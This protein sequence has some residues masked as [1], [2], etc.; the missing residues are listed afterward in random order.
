MA[1][2]MIMTDSPLIS[3][4][5]SRV[6]REIALG[7]QRYGHHIVYLGWFSSPSLDNKM[8]F[9]LYRTNNMYYGQDAFDSVFLQEQPE[10][11]LT[12]GDEWMV[13][14]LNNP[15]YCSSRQ[16]LKWIMYCPVDGASWNG[17]IPS[18]WYDTLRSADYLIAYTEYGRRKILHS[19]PELF[20]QVRVIYHGVD[21]D[22]FRPLD[23]NLI[24]Q[25]RA[26]WGLKDKIVFLM[27]SRNQGRKNIPEFCKAWKK[28]K[29]QRGHENCKFWPH[30]NFSDAMGWNLK[31][32][33][34]IY[35][36]WKDITYFPDIA[37]GSNNLATLPEDV[38]N[39]L[40]N[41]CDVHCLISGEG[42]GLPTFE[43]MAC[44]KPVINLNHSANTEITE[45][46]GELVKVKDYITG[47]HS[48]ER[49]LPDI[50]DLVDKM[51]KLAINPEL[52]QQ[53]GEKGY[54]FAQKYTWR[55]VC[56][57]WNELIKE[58]ENPLMK[59]N[60]VKVC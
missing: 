7:L 30:M 60:F 37:D 16:F 1:K 27:V 28:F 24:E 17:G 18:T 19:L 51:H 40:Y 31:E 15:Q 47:H 55:N 5:M 49:P 32:I 34:T 11:V 48:T 21:T 6:G 4:G 56:K 13:N 45:G 59:P 35:D 23:K 46:R 50:D 42:F 20:G 53:Y 52:R 25:K 10:I 22:V 14:Y 29:L 44:K 8:P 39:L 41:V 54:K 12:I 58:I 9:K 2:I 57:E 26:E 43:A 33:F 38:L 3:T 36:M